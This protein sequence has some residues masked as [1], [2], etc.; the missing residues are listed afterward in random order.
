MT[1]WPDPASPPEPALENADPVLPPPFGQARSF[2][3]VMVLFILMM[4]GMMLV[5]G[6]AQ[7]FLGFAANAILTEFVVVLGPVWF[8]LRKGRPAE[9]LNLNRRPDFGLVAWAM[10]GVLC[11]A[12]LVAEFTHWSDLVFPMPE[13][14]KAAYLD[15]VTAESVSEMLLLV[16]AAGLVPGLCEEAA[17]RGFFQRV[18]VSRYGARGGIVF[19]SVLFAL[20]HLDPWH[21]VALFAIGLYLGFVYHWTGNLWIP[22][23]AHATNNAASVILLYLSPESSLSQLSEPPPRWLLP[24]AVAGLWLTLR[25]LRKAH[26]KTSP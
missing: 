19:A 9:A 22:A 5:G 13:M 6:A 12:V 14:V 21:L 3:G 1:I 25:H 20:M 8:L 18:G 15:A 24:I 11:L 7:F 10:L 17:F 4:L 16:L 23:A 2:G 26:Q